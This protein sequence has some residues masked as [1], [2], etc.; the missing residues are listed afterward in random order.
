MTVSMQDGR[1][2]SRLEAGNKSISLQRMLAWESIM[3]FEGS[4]GLLVC[5]PIGGERSFLASEI[6][7]FSAN[8]IVFAHPVRAKPEVKHE[9]ILCLA[10]ESVEIVSR[11]LLMASVAG[12]EH[13]K[14]RSTVLDIVHRNGLR[15]DW[16]DTPDKCKYLPSLLWIGDETTRKVEF[17]KI[18]RN[19]IHAMFAVSPMLMLIQQ[20][21]KFWSSLKWRRRTIYQ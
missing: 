5:V 2:V 4:D 21:R 3:L 13:R 8:G 15:E 12:K 6:V 7:A 18:E 9:I 19:C 17:E 20:P 10:R 1:V 16:G 14:L 11:K